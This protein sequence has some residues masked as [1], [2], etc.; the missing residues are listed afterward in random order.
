MS[1]RCGCKSRLACLKENDTQTSVVFILFWCFFSRIGLKY[2]I[3]TIQ[4]II[5]SLNTLTLLVMKTNIDKLFLL[6][7]QR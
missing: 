1:D 6:V 2:L 3:K 5:P 4:I 7:V